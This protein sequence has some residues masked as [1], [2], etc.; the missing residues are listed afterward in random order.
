MTIL[1]SD[2]KLV[3]TQVMDDV[4]NGG[5]APTSNVIPDGASNKVFK[6]ISAVDRAQGDTSIMKI[7]ATVQTL[8]TD[9]ALGGTVI[10][11]RMPADP[12]VTPLLF[13]TGDFFDQRAAIQA[14]IEAYT[15]PGEEFSGF[16]L[17]N[18]VQGQKSIQIF[19][20]PGA[21]PPNT[22]S[23][24]QIAGGGKSEA[25]RIANVAVEQRTY[26]Y[27]VSNSFVDYSAQVC[28]CEI[29]DGLKNDY[30]GTPA[31]RLYER[32]GTSAAINRMLVAD[33]ARFYGVS[34]LV[35]PATRGSLSVKVDRISAQLVPSAT[36]EIPLADIGASGSSQALVASGSG[37]VSLPTSAVFGPNVAFTLGNS[38]FPGSLSIATGAGTI[39]DDGGR[40]KL[41][42]QTIGSIGYASGTFTFASDAPQIIGAK[43]ITFRPAGAPSQLA[44]SAS[45]AVSI[46]NR[47]VN[48]PLTILPPPAPGTT[49]VAFRAG[50]N[51][52]ELADDGA[53]RLR[54]VDSSSGSGS[55][56]FTTGTVMPTLGA[57]PDVGSEVLY[58]WGAKSSYR[59]RSGV[60]PA[61]L[62][63][64]LALD[65]LAAQSGT[66][67]VD[68]NDGTAHHAADN[69]SGALTGDATGPV[70]YATSTLDVRPNSV[71]ASSV[72]FT[73]TYSHGEASSKSF[74][75]PARDVDGGI[76]L[77]L[78]ATN[79]APRSIELDWNL[80][81]MSTGG[82]PPELW[83]PQ[84]FASTKTVL[85][86]GAGKLVD[87]AGV[88]FGTV[89]YSTGVA[90]LYPEA[91]VTIPVPQWA[92]NELGVLGTVL[93]P[94][95]PGAFRNTLTGYSYVPLSA[96][97]PADSTALV[98]ARFRVAGAGTS[99]SQV[100]NAPKLALKLLPNASEVGVPGSVNFTFGGKN[101]FDRAG[102][103]YTDLDAAT[104]A[105]TLA[106]NYDYTTN[107]ATLTAWPASASST[108]TV[109]SLLTSLDGQPVDYVVFRAPVA[110]ISPG[111]LQLLATKLTGGTI[112]VTAS[113]AGLIEAT[114]VHGT[115]DAA[116]GV[117]KVRFG[118]WVTAAGH[119]GE[120]WYDPDAIGS[121][122]KIWKPVPV[123]ANTIRYNTVAT[124]MLPIDAAQLGL[125]PVRLPADGRPPIY[126]KGGLTVIGNAQ[127]MPAAVV[128]A[129]QTLDTG[130]E[131]LAHVRVVDDDGDTIGNGYIVNYDA[132]M[133]TFTDV[134]GY[135]QPVAVEH[136]IEDMLTATDIQ[137]DGRITFQSR[138]SHDYP[139][140]GTYVSSALRMGDVKAR[141]AVLFVQH[142]WTGEWADSLIGNA[143]DARYDDV[144]YPVLLTN[145]GAVTERWRLQF[146]APGV[147]SVIGE[148]LGVI[149]TG[150]SV[151]ADCSPVGPSG[152]PYFTIFAAGLGQGWAQGN[153]VRFN[154]V[155]AT[156]P[157]VVIRCVQMGA[158]TVLDDSFEVMVRVGVDRP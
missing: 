85:D 136:R 41:S 72:A 37:T 125:D 89:V 44:D 128:A 52:Y 122:G 66:V 30:A 69:G 28:V 80:V 146:T 96:T 93:S 67:A 110:P 113:L 81:L 100:F 56:D 139:V 77:N 143:P 148:H 22:N 142:T 29:L 104:G 82:V 75:A 54:G 6:D 48:Y 18:H 33:A 74:P 9:T 115:V 127:R 47:R 149:V 153:L 91:I 16:L 103:L 130:R 5:G 114:N 92:V 2:I 36:T 31:N 65:N 152:V 117:G 150:Q 137:I 60:L 73:V 131:R 8:N 126:R 38:A 68:W 151:T 23:T 88:E 26:S 135:K 84:N 14:R 79:I 24:L 53:G 64:P 20:R 98:S 46:E 39:T 58:F 132:G 25:V 35:E 55:V 108:V 102:A 76:T 57:L 71:P 95:L 97:L 34:K 87:G 157:F 119:E 51:W 120:S 17:S 63:I 154:T 78:G 45:V 121:D 32:T 21:T 105:A 61:A 3:T 123:F 12:G 90:K 1:E 7:A 4:S 158:E 116:T 111:T 27:S 109:N 147:Y 106:G 141:T 19:Q 118:D 134:T 11:S 86:N 10:I 156:F 101:Y 49:R 13:Y 94:S 145:K 133:V 129:G 99:K 83:V 124:T 70:S 15:T 62:S 59:D 144:N 42:G 140:E 50:G 107:V 112:N 40:L 155:A 43:T 138:L